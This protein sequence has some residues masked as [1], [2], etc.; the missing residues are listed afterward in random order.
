MRSRFLALKLFSITIYLIVWLT[1]IHEMYGFVPDNILVVA[2][3]YVY[4]SE[5]LAVVAL[6]LGQH[7][8]LLI[9]CEL[10][11]QLARVLVELDV[12]A[13]V[14]IILRKETNAVAL[15]HDA[16]HTLVLIVFFFIQLL[17]II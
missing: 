10:L 2:I 7:P 11:L 3:V 12:R 17:L 9:V 1:F 14:R 4:L 6:G 5:I 13:Q 15:P 8:S 16:S